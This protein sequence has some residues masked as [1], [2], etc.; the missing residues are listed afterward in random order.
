MRQSFLWFLAV[1]F[2]FQELAQAENL[3]N[4]FFHHG[5]AVPISNKRGTVATVDG[6]G[7][8]IVLVWLHDHRGG[9]ALLEINTTTGA[10]KQYPLPCGDGP[11]TSLLSSRNK[12]YTHYN[13]NFIEFD[14]N[15][16]KLTVINHDAPPQMAMSMT[17]DDTGLIW[18]AT[19]PQCGL[20]SYN[21]ATKEL[22]DHGP[23]FNQD[24]AVYP[25]FIA[26]DEKGWMYAAIGNTASHII[27]FNPFT[28]TSVRII[29][30][31]ERIAG[32]G[33]YVYRDIDGRV[34]GKASKDKRDAWYRFYDG[35]GEKI[36]RHA[37]MHAKKI[38]TGDWGLFH[39]QFPDGKRLKA[40][41]LEQRSIVV[42]DPSASSRLKRINFN[43]TSEGAN[44][45]N[46]TASPQ[47]GVMCGATAFPMFA[48]IY[49]PAHDHLI[50]H[51]CYNQWNTLSS[52]DKKIYIGGYP[53][54]CLLEWEPSKLWVPTVK[55]KLMPSA[56]PRFIDEGHPTVGRPHKVLAHPDGNTVI[57]A[58]TPGYGLTGGG[59]L[60][61][62]T[63]ERTTRILKDADIIP[64]QS[65]A[66]LVALPKGML[67]GGTTTTPGTG[68]IKKAKEAELYCLDL[69]SK[70]LLWHQNVIP[71][72][73][74]YL[75][76]CM[77][78]KGMV[79][80]IADR[81]LF[82]AFDPVTRR[83]V[84]TQDISGFGPMPHQQ[85][86]RFFINGPNGG[87]YVLFRKGIA[88]IDQAG[89]TVTWL[90]DAP[91][92]I[93]AGGDV[94]NGALFFASNSHIYSYNLH[95]FLNGKRKDSGA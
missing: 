16:R 67:L 36:G 1:L 45:M 73:Q 6:D 95:S 19:Y 27:A 87:I 66:S 56:N 78:D 82:F 85:G 20:V 91:V 74:E 80:G 52:S 18:A 4:G 40:C 32:K 26:A 64:D 90:A 15:Q 89:H 8:D 81:R 63:K 55:N 37:P 75:D 17:E 22:R 44:I 2:I 9:Y 59:L 70:E 13:N 92:P 21:P 42:E 41:D 50:S 34:Y 3:G 43:Y 23:V 79:Y 28:G 12:F 62:N 35:R 25:S 24:W 49:N 48:F 46:L 53:D 94:L 31:S 51:P 11:Y 33:A 38:T 57:L 93:T 65:T 86:P 14:I 30:E 39:H 61:W 83:I 5:A 84:H 10:S 58:G 69:E 54:G 7:A 71:G 60:I 29:P 72:A 76:L 68:G 47:A 88:R 77:N